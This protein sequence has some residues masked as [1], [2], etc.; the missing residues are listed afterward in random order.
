MRWQSLPLVAGFAVLVLIVGSRAMLVE[1]QRAN[2]AAAREAIEYQQ[3]LSGLLSLAQE[4]ENGQRGYLLTGEKSYL[5]PYRSAVRAI[6]GQLARID[7]LTAPDDQLVQPINHIK[8]ALSQKQAEL[9]ETIALYDQGNATNALDLVRSGQGKAVMDEIRTS[10]DTVR[11]IS[12]AAIAARDAHTDQVE[13]WL[14]IG[15]LAALLAIFL[16]AGYAIRESRRRFREVAVAQDE[17]V[18]KNVA[19]GKE[20]ETREKAESQIRQMHKMEAVGQLTGGIAHD[21]NNMLAVIIS[22]M[23]LAQRKLARGEHDIAQFIDAAIDAATR[24][25]NLTARLLA[26]SRQQPLAPQ[27]VDANR[28]LTGMSD[29]IRRALGET[30]RIETVLAGG[31]W[32]THADPSQI[33][34]AVLNLAVNARDAMGDDGKLTIETANS[35]LDDSYAAAH[36]EVAAGQYVM[37]AVSDTGSGM[38]PDVIS[39]AFEPFFTTKA[40]NKGT[41][42]GLSQVFGFVKQSGGHVNI[43]SEPGEGTTIKIYLPR[44][45]GPEEPAVPTGRGDN[46]AAPVTETIL[47]V[48]DDARVRVS[49]T[50]A[51][52]ELGYT[53]IHAA[54]GEEALQ[55]LAE[56]PNV[57]LLFTDIVMPVMNGRKLAEEAVA[58]MPLLKVIFTTGF[59]RNA[60]VHNGV[61]DHDVHF[62]AKPFTIE[63][64]AAKLRDVLG[65]TQVAAD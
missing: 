42:L 43:Y 9:A 60:V 46:T 54:S 20:I 12:A 15:S 5:E 34:N 28:L 48:E 64:L 22:A 16:L 13:A 33:E 59:T 7:S 24:A 36:A 53:V 45:F 55:K 65:T 6:P 23:N 51:I 57:A 4:A 47:V 37:I 39:K 27:I 19:L 35:H 56:N 38:T 29:L 30:I 14:R 49:T 61:L 8:D 32:K 3:L 26:F 31:L 10:M 62:L 63:Q 40:V 17:L 41:G 18:R 11:R 1:E 50:E 2:R 58:R 44:Y 52:R 25:A 21:F